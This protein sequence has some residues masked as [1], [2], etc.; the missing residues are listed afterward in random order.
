MGLSAIEQG[1]AKGKGV[2]LVT[3][4]FGGI[5]FIPTYLA[6][7]NYP[8]TILV[9]FSSNHLRKISNETG[10]QSWDLK[11]LIPMIVLMS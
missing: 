6:A 9:K 11:L 7:R 5:E 4:H 8:V 3:G 1:I 2:L 10:R